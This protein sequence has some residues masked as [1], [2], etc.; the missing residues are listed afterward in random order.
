MH[1]GIAPRRTTNRARG[2]LWA[3]VRGPHPAE[4]LGMTDS[5]LL[6][7]SE[8]APSPRRALLALAT[9]ALAALVFPVSMSA[10]S[11]DTAL[12]GTLELLHGET[13]D[14][15][16]ATYEYHL[17][18]KTERVKLHF[19]GNAPEGF[20]NG[21]TIRIK[22]HRE[23]ANLVALDGATG[24]QVLASS[25]GWSGQRKVAV[26]LVNFSNNASQPFTRA[27]ASGI[28]FTNPNSVRAYYAEQSHGAVSLT[29]TAFDWV[30]IPYSNATCQPQVWEGAAKAALKARGVDLSTYTNFMFLFPQTNAC[31]WRGMGYLP[32]A[33]TWINGAPTLRT[34]AHEL[35][36]NFGVHHA[37]SLRCTSNGIR[38]ALSSTCT[39]SE[40]GDPFS[41]MGA[42]PNRHSTNLALVQMGY[43]GATS[44]QTIVAGGTYT[45]TQASAGGGVR[46]L[47]IPRGDG[48]WIYL[49]YRRP[50]GTYFDNFSSSDPGVKGVSIKLGGSWSTI[51]QTRLIDTVPSTTTFADAPLRLGM[52][53][54]DYVS[55]AVIKVVYL[56]TST[57]KVTVTLPADT[58][59]PSAPGAFVAKGT[60]TSTSQLTWTAASD[61]RQVAG[62]YVWRGYTL[63]AT[64]ARTVLAFSDTGLAGGTTYDYAISAF[65]GAG[66]R[67]ALAFASAATQPVDTAPSA[68]VAAIDQVNSNWATVTWTASVDNLGVVSYRV[69]RLGVLSATTASDVREARVSPDGSYTVV[70]VDAAGNVSPASNQVTP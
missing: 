24:A 43:I 62:Y 50:Y 17:R 47:G 37:S 12:E 69:Y 68:P 38:V 33:T 61:N 18:T 19:K 16:G 11:S 27:F 22:G 70:A 46:I 23:G 14:T 55:G 60:S 63:V 29:G 45:L 57:A 35:G 53:F 1:D 26:I 52:S 20:V 31:P 58:K 13:T 44:T 41:T 59:A 2:A 51:T 42:S 40:Y 10:A 36:H 4:P 39:V 5:A 28:L 34:S 56:G 66:N 48:S 30:Q 9:V 67:S 8:R 21:A 32:G 6:A 65:D 7:R 3:M 49:E 64:T 25:P 54:R 15:S